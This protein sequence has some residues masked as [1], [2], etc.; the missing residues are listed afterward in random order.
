MTAVC[1]NVSLNAVRSLNLEFRFWVSECH[2]HQMK[3]VVAYKQTEVSIESCY[4]CTV[5]IKW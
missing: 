2:T 5:G 3:L 4:R 1:A